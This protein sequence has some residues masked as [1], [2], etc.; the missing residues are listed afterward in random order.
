MLTIID[1]TAGG[2]HYSMPSDTSQPSSTRAANAV[3][4][5]SVHRVPLRAVEMQT[6]FP[7]SVLWLVLFPPFILLPAPLRR[8]P[9]LGPFPQ[10]AS[11][12]ILLYSP[13]LPPFASPMYLFVSPCS[14][15]IHK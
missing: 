11:T 7:P 8:S 15:A 9:Q 2:R 4:Q 14:L 3:N 6:A 13:C 1:Q 10:T 12:L 5:V